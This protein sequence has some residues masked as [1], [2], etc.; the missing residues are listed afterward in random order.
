[1]YRFE[2]YQIFNLPGWWRLPIVTI[3]LWWWD[4]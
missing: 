1:M 3:L 4:W 2:I